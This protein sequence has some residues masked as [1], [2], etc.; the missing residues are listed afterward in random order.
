MRHLSF[1][2]ALIL[3]CSTAADGGSDGS[4]T[5]SGA[6]A[7]GSGADTGADTAGGTPGAAS[8]AGDGDPGDADG[9]DTT[10]AADSGD[11]GD[12]GGSGSA[13]DAGDGGAASG[14]GAGSDGAGSD[15]GASDGADPATPWPA[16]PPAYDGQCPTFTTGAQ[17]FE[18]GGHSRTVRVYLPSTPVESPAVLF[19]WHA[20]GANATLFANLFSAQKTAD[21]RG[22]IVVVPESCCNPQAEWDPV[23]DSQLFDDMMSCLLES[24][25]ADPTRVY[26]TGFSAGG[27]WSTWLTMHRGDSLAAGVIFSGGV[28][29]WLPYVTPAARVPVVL[30]DGGPFD[31]YGG[32]VNFHTMTAELAEKLTADGHLVIHCVHS[33]G[34]VI[35]PGADAWGY[36]FL[37]AHTFGVDSP[38]DEL[39][40]T[41]PS[42]C[43]LF[44]PSASTPD[45]L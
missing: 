13:S 18:S 14:D 35:P 41:W 11:S 4:T 36:P 9:N 27:L 45:P 15:G 19:V 20:L 25:D 30:V 8:D 38:Y 1:T 17:Q 23:A 7:G 21:E 2:F 40:G 10:G 16:A 28:T 5:D 34:H 39:D 44:P 42:Y 24:H 32:F 26:T 6:T 12:G 3:G 29:T 37:F 22:A 43:E 33:G 31:L